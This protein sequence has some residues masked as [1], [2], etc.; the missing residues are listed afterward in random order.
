MLS[1]AS[2][3]QRPV[4]DYGVLPGVKGPGAVACFYEGGQQ[5]Y[6]S[7]RM[8]RFNAAWLQVGVGQS[9]GLPGR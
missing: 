7:I 5:T 9:P 4:G 8:A 1:L 6:E 3:R 2:M